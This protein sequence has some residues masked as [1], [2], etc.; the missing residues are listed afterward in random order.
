MDWQVYNKVITEFDSI[1][2]QGMLVF[3]MVQVLKSKFIA[4][5]P[6]IYASWLQQPSNISSQLEP[7]TSSQKVQE[8]LQYACERW[9]NAYEE[10]M[11]RGM[12]EEVI[13]DKTKWFDII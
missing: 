13:R 10:A 9:L 11:L 6:S 3:G 4:V 12:R 7:I 1:Q 2:E 8:Q 5:K